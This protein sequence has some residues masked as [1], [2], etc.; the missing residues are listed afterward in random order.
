MLGRR[1][2]K[3]DAVLGQPLGVGLVQ[4][5][6]H[7]ETVIEALLVCLFQG[8]A[9]MVL[10]EIFFPNISKDKWCNEEKVP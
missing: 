7:G 3:D 6:E 4:R 5:V 9:G 1:E 8:I 10:C 2:Q